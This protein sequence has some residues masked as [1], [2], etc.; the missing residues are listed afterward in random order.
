MST[1]PLAVLT[2]HVGRVWHVS[3]HPSG[4]LLASCGEDKTVRL[5]GR[6]GEG[7]VC[8]TVLTEGH[9]RT[10]RRVNWS[11]CGHYLATAS[12]DG[13][14][15]VW[16]KK[17][18]EY[19][20]GA[21]LEGHEN[22]VK[23]VV[24]SPGGEF[25]ATCSRDKSVWLW[26]VDTEDDEYSCAS[27][28]HSHT[29]D[30]KAVAWHPE[31]PVLASC[32]YDNTIKLYRED[33]DDWVAVS[34]LSS[35]TNTVWDI[36]WDKAGERLASCSEDTSVKIWQSYG[37]GNNQ[38]IQNPGGGGEPAW[39]CV[40]TLSGYHCRAIYSLDWGEAG[41]VTGGGDDTVRVWREAGEGEA[42]EWSVVTTLADC[43]DMDVNCVAWNP[44][45]CGLLA[46]CSEYDDLSRETIHLSVYKVRKISYS[47]QFVIIINN[48]KAR[49]HVGSRK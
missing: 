21:S 8:R 36:A 29:Q 35:H 14:V 22:E 25:L 41:L 49:N 30:V 15:A 13:T 23:C 24:W 26:D 31:L 37:P 7:W 18:G 33:G 46:T 32:S 47:M 1:K 38:G 4:D 39:K 34:T 12:F 40:A 28:L 16:D 48:V 2:G 45:Q 17:S 11:P 44:R 10:V 5:W 27:V 42:A 20:C 43:H 3:W 9:T 19:E 6:A